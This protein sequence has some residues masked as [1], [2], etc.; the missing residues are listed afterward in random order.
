MSKK[1]KLE[2]VKIVL[3]ALVMAAKAIQTGSVPSS[4]D[5]DRI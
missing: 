5:A 3:A 2:I 1:R 4:T